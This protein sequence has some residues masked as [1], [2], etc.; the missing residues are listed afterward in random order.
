MA[1]GAMQAYRSNRSSKILLQSGSLFLCS[2]MGSDQNQPPQPT[3][4]DF[5]SCF[6]FCFVSFWWQVEAKD[7]AENLAEQSLGCSQHCWLAT[8][9]VAIR[10]ATIL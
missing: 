6:V 4:V 9:M 8:F 3:D 10:Q 2:Q 5:C 7:E 1:V